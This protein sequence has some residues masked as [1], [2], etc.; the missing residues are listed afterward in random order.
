MD[1]QNHNINSG[2]NI[3]NTTTTTLVQE[4]NPHFASEPSQVPV[5]IPQDPNAVVTSSYPGAVTLSQ[6]AIV[7]GREL[8]MMNVFLVNTIK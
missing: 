4:E 2:H 6:P 5:N 3:N 1:Q 7:I 8:E